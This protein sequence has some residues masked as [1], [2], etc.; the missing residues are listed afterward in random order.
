MNTYDRIIN[1]LLEA[2]IEDYI[3][4]LD[5][6]KSDA[7]LSIKDKKIHRGLRNPTPPSEY[8]PYVSSDANRVAHHRKTQTTARRKKTIRTLDRIQQAELDKL[9]QPK[10]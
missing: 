8:D 2:R 5:E 9:L 4:R 6:A 3:E 10:K 1:M 7:G